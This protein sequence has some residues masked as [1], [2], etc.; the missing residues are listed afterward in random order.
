M[1][2]PG[3]TLYCCSEKRSITKHILLLFMAFH[4]YIFVYHLWKCGPKIPAVCCTATN[5]MVCIIHNVF[6]R[7][8]SKLIHNI[9][10]N[11]AK[12]PLV[13]SLVKGTWRHALQKPPN[14]K[15]NILRHTCTNNHPVTI[16]SSADAVSMDQ[17]GTFQLFAM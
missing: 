4:N 14:L 16:I 8:S 11:A 12:I 7:A 3:N 6:V 17:C 5:I 1:Y 13:S 10:K 15:V 2:F 9:G